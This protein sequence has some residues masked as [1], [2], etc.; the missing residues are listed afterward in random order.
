MLSCKIR[1]VENLVPENN[2]CFKI[3]QCFNEIVTI[4]H[5]PKIRAR[6]ARSLRH[7]FVAPHCVKRLTLRTPRA[8]RSAE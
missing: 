5:A 1:I 3:T 8:T 7:A 6:T 2:N 4:R